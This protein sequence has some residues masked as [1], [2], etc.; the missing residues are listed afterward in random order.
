M[1]PAPRLF[2]VSD[3]TPS[4]EGAVAAIR[5]SRPERRGN[6]VERRGNR[7]APSGRVVFRTTGE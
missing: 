6:G 2:A 3:Q 1:F 5:E 7:L 4:V